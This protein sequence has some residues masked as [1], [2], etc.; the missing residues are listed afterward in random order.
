MQPIY[1]SFSAVMLRQQQ[2][3]QQQYPMGRLPAYRASYLR[4]Y[5]P[6][7]RTNQPQGGGDFLT[8]IDHRFDEHPYIPSGSFKTATTSTPTVTAETSGGLPGSNSDDASPATYDIDIDVEGQFTTI[9]RIEIIDVD[10]S[11][12]P[13]PTPSPP[14]HSTKRARC[15]RLLRVALAELVVRRRPLVSIRSTAALT[16]IY[17]PQSPFVTLVRMCRGGQS[18]QDAEEAIEFDLMSIY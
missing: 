16:R 6:Y 5:H 18:V 7:P 15:R 17:H 13:S 3:Q 1:P 4:R 9:P 12:P 14:T 11:R 8:T 2:Q 10:A